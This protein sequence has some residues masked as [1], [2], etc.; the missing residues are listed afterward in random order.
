M[1]PYHI[2]SA[3]VSIP[4]V[5]HLRHSARLPLSSPLTMSAIPIILHLHCISI[6]VLPRLC[7]SPYQIIFHLSVYFAAF[8][9]AFSDWIF[10]LICIVLYYTAF[11]AL[12]HT[13][14]LT[15]YFDLLSK[16][17]FYI[18][19][20]LFSISVMF[21]ICSNLPH[22][23]SLAFTPLC[24]TLIILLSH[25]CSNLIAPSLICSTMIA[26]LIL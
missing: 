5:L 20:R 11:S 25:I 10:S 1:F 22:F 24:S 19:A 18:L 3:A 16:L 2:S 9:S 4:V 15:L 6:V 14:F 7:C 13:N 26:L 21:L 12:L 23:F 17:L 8:L